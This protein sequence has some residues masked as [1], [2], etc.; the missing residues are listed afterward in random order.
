MRPSIAEAIL[1]KIEVCGTFIIKFHI[2]IHLLKDDSR[3][4]E[5][6]WHSLV[7]LKIVLQ[8]PYQIREKPHFQRPC[9]GAFFYWKR[10][11]GIL[12]A[13]SIA[14]ANLLVTLPSSILFFMYTSTIYYLLFFREINFTKFFREIDFTKKITYLVY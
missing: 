10:K 1:N 14:S 2:E 11:L 5:N 13:S 3:Y 8:P 4:H 12:A 9:Y 6:K 7:M